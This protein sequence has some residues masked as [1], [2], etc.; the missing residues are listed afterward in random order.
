MIHLIVYL[1]MVSVRKAGNAHVG[2]QGRAVAQESRQSRMADKSRLPSRLPGSHHGPAMLI[3]LF[4]LSIQTLEAGIDM[5]GQ[6]SGISDRDII[7]DESREGCVLAD[8]IIILNA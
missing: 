5:E 1:S 8:G 2:E 4:A 3:R 6:A 7:P